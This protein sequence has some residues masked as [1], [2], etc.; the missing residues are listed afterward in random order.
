LN[1]KRKIYDCFC[2]KRFNKAQNIYNHYI[3]KHKGT[4]PDEGK[5]QAEKDFFA[6][7]KQ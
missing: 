4:E 2:G 3:V 1:A 7:I 5:S 6:H